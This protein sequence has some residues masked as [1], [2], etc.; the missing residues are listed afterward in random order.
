MEN[1]RAIFSLNLAAFLIYKNHKN[2]II[3]ED[4]ENKKF[5]LI[6]DDEVEED[7][8]EYRRNDCMVDLHRFLECYKR[9]RKDI[10]NIRVNCK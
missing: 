2:Y 4:A 5:F 8:R 3:A 6:F 1:N 9:L 7:I 10:N